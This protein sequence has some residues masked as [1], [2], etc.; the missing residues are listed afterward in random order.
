MFLLVEARLPNAML[1]LA[2][3]RSRNFSGANL[4]TLFLYTALGGGMFFFPLNGI[5]GDAARAPPGC[6]LLSLCF[7]CR[8]GRVDW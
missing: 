5:H 6:R 3:F 1:P 7:C 8:A 4:L 2:L